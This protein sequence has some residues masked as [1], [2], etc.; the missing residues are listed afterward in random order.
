[1]AKK[2]M[3]VFT[4]VFSML[5]VGFTTTAQ[6]ELRQWAS[7]AEATSEF[8]ATDYSASRA[9]GAP[10]AMAECADSVNAWA[11]LEATDDEALT[12]YY[13][14]AVKP[15]Q[16]NIHQNFSPGAISSVE[17]IPEEGN[18]TIPIA[19]SQDTSTACP[20]I[21]S[22]D[23]SLDTKVIGV[24][25]HVDQVAIANWN[26]IDAVE[27]VGTRSRTLGAGPGGGPGGNNTN[28]GPGGGPGGGNSA[29]PPPTLVPVPPS[30]ND[31]SDSGGYVAPDG[32]V[33]VDVTCPDGRQITNG[34]KI[35]VV[36]MRTGF[37]YTATAIGMNGFD[38]VLAVLDPRGRAA[39][40][41]DDERGAA[42]Y[43]A[44][45]PTTGYIPPAST[46]SQVPFRNVG[47][48]FSDVSL[49]VGGFNE[50][51]EGEFVLVLEGMAYTEL[52]N[53][54]DPFAM[55]IT[56]G[57]I[58]SGVDPTIY[59]VSVTDRLDPYISMI[60]TEYNM[61]VDEKGNQI[62]YCDDAGNSDYCYGNSTTMVGSYISRASNRPNLGGYGLDA[63]LTLPL[64]AGDEFFT[65]HAL[66]HSSQ[67]R[68]YG[69]YL[70]AFH[71]AIGNPVGSRA[72]A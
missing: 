71:L 4:T 44:D 12:L 67:F 22:I 54:G 19:N 8:T 30:N 61:Y 41:N 70:V 26:E 64:E 57:M 13:D 43:S 69:N 28:D 62:W 53:V 58:A 65:V 34:I 10:D 2:M 55:E 17:L 39:L 42:N 50:G 33:G 52:D 29:P 48:G 46:T 20:G 60:D 27:L 14:T 38:P 51:D 23:V 1:M 3:I 31:N 40:C 11:S 47:S 59:M 68:T 35:T 5:V 15:T 18:F 21:F 49:V 66:M 37:D 7:S 32:P 9:T 72:D 36:Q 63:M 24:V 56:P 16:I 45:L 6:T 25:I